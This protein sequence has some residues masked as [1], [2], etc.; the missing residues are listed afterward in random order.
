M[1][2]KKGIIIK[3]CF[4]GQRHG[5]DNGRLIQLKTLCTPTVTVHSFLGFHTSMIF[6]TFIPKILIIK[7]FVLTTQIICSFVAA[8]GAN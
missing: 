4:G 6:S 1:M 7:K 3:L 8:D 2:V 5:F